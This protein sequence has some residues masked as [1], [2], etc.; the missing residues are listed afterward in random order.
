MLHFTVLNKPII[1]TI[2]YIGCYHLSFTFIPCIS[3]FNSAMQF[4]LIMHISCTFSTKTSVWENTAKACSSF[5]KCDHEQ[6]SNTSY[7]GCLF[8][9]PQLLYK[10]LTQ[11]QIC[12]TP[13]LKSWTSVTTTDKLYWGVNNGNQHLYFLQMLSIKWKAPIYKQRNMNM[14]DAFI[15]KWLC[16][17]FLSKRWNPGITKCCLL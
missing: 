4:N 12:S 17:H 8:Y 7:L 16:H 5:S 2:F 10:I 6:G 14:K 9:N 11:K 15:L 3:S 1:W 13:D